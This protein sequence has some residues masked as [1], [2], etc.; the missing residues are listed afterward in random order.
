MGFTLSNCDFK[1]SI[2]RTPEKELA[3]KINHDRMKLLAL[4]PPITIGSP[5][6][7]NWGKA[8]AA[9]FLFHAH[10]WQFTAT[11]IDLLFESQGKFSKFWI[12]N[13]PKHPMSGEC[14]IAVENAL[15]AIHL[16]RTA[17]ANANKAIA[18]LTPAELK[19]KIS[20]L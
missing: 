16:N 3:D 11:D 13:R 10:A 5:K 15:E 17:D 9:Q 2:I 4:D 14:R 12:D 8:I 19:R 7:I 1:S 6:Q 20:R 18:Q